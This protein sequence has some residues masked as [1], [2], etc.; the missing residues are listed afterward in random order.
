MSI[1]LFELK[2]QDLRR[3]VDPPTLKSVGLEGMAPI[4][5]VVGQKRAVAALE[6]GLG[7][8][9]SGFNV[10]VSGPPGLGKMTAVKAYLEKFA[11]TRP[12]P[13]DWCYV[14]NFEDPYLPGILDLPAGKGRELQQ[15]MKTFLEQVRRDVTRALESEE[16]AARKEEVLRGLETQKAERVQG[17]N[18]RANR[19]GFVVQATP[20]GIAIVP[21]A[22]NRAITDAEFQEMSADQKLKLQQKQESLQEELQGLT[23]QVRQIEREAHEKLRE[24]DRKMILYVVGDHM[25]D[26]LQKFAELPP[27]IEYLKSV[28]SSMSENMEFFKTKREDNPLAPLREPDLQFRKYQ[29]NVLVDH[30]KQEG[31]PVVVELNPSYSNLFGRVEKETVYGALHT[32]FTLIKAGSLHQANGG[33]IVLEAYEVLRNPFSWDGLKRMLNAREIQIEDIGDRLGLISTKGLRPA[34][35][36][37]HV[38]V[39][40]VGP[41]ILY[42]L[43]LVYDPDF[44]ELFKVKAEFDTRMDR[45]DENIQA[46][47][48]FLNTFGTK[49]NIAPLEASA[50]ARI[51]EHASRLAE[52][53]EKLSTHFG[54]LADTVREANYWAGREGAV[55]VNASHVQR[56]LDERMRRSNLVQ[57]RMQEMTVR[58]FL[59][60]ETS[61]KVVGQVNGL[62]VY[63]LGDYAFGRPSRITASV[64]PGRDGILDI[65]REVKLG[66]PIHSKGVMILSGYLAQKFAPDRPLTLSARLVF[67]QSYEGVEGDS[68]SSAELYSLLSAL[69]GLPI[70]QGIAITG[71]VNQ[72]GEIQAIGGANEKIEGFFDLCLTRGLTGTQGVMMPESN[73]PNLMLRQEIVE[74]VR[75]GRFHIWAVQ[76]IDQ[77]IEVLTGVPAGERGTDGAFPD[78]TV[79]QLVQRRLHDFSESLKKMSTPMDT[80]VGRTDEH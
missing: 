50:V 21:V 18:E 74:A 64:A 22:G 30:I 75:E 40:L 37:L 14:N 43:L 31:A 20:F 15:Q 45:N 49:E 55:Q 79:N 48:G 27:V 65:E 46:F 35:V 72:R 19:E 1:E 69:S 71:S 60:I 61:G 42:H 25:D 51:L 52:D 9:D 5:G 16:Y 66:G 54:T 38:K 11:R 29:V 39:I 32:D 8:L 73:V 36:P 67:E 24:L 76:T 12:T 4:D 63:S 6:L 41:P 53:K 23:K 57:E 28:Q 59:K 17:F 34:P 70:D 10:Y 62:S 78:G 58:G 2:P 56:A 68:A 26:L 47:L 13:T 7:I 80:D 33:Y 77:G 3:S 44:S